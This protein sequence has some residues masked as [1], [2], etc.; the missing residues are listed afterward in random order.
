MRDRKSC[1]II[2]SDLRASIPATFALLACSDAPTPHGAGANDQVQRAV[3]AATSS[4]L[5]SPMRAGCVRTPRPLREDGPLRQ[6]GARADAQAQVGLPA[7]IRAHREMTTA[8]RNP[9]YVRAGPPATTLLKC[10]ST[11]ARHNR[12]GS[13]CS[14][15]QPAP[16]WTP[17]SCSAHLGRAPGVRVVGRWGVCITR[18]W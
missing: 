2:L 7:G 6:G 14:D 12:H 17:Q 8:A 11:R 18:S 5:G 13:A 15:T 1:I 3:R 16:G 10:A 4:R 9:C